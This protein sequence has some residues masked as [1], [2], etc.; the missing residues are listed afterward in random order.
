MPSKL[1]D[2]MTYSF[3]NFNGVT[4]EVWEGIVNFI[5]HFMMYVITYSF[6]DIIPVLHIWWYKCIIG[7]MN[8]PCTKYPH[9]H[10]YI[11]SNVYFAMVT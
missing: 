5:P 2:E 11:H 8:I 4:V 3:P 6:P 10:D 7:T 1:W 9:S